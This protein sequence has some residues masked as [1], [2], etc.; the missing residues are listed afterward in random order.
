MRRQFDPEQLATAFE[1]LNA[2]NKTQLSV[3]LQAFGGGSEA[4]LDDLTV[5]LRK[6]KLRWGQ[7]TARQVGLLTCLHGT[8]LLL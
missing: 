7:P 2:G 8:Q 4:D 5:A 3:L 1:R 6:A